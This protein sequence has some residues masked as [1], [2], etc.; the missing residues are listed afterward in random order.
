MLLTAQAVKSTL[1]LVLASAL[2]G[3]SGALGYRGSL[4]VAG[5][6]AP[7]DQR[8]EV[9][10]TYFAAVF[11]GNALPIIGIGLL[12]SFAGSAPAH[13]VFGMMIAGL[14]VAALVN[15]AEYAPLQ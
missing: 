7:I 8:S 14:A 3:V 6:I 13:V 4:E 10:S 2:S 5:R 9:I 11:A 15:G 1:I 12:P